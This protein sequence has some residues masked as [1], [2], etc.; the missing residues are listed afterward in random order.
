MAMRLLS[1]NDFYHEL[2]RRGCRT[3][4]GKF[5]FGRF[6]QGPDGRY[7]LVPPP[8]EDGR[9]PDWMLDD[10]IRRHNLPPPKRDH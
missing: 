8:E 3:T 7:F 9:Y 2:E 5:P 4:D 1:P 10:L 6:W